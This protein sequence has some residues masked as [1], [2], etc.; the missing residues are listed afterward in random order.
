MLFFIAF[1]IHCSIWKW[2][3][4]WSQDYGMESTYCKREKRRWTG[5]PLV[6]QICWKYCQMSGTLLNLFILDIWYRFLPN[7]FSRYPVPCQIFCQFSGILPNISGIPGVY[8]VHLDQPPTP[9]IIF[10]I[11]YT[12]PLLYSAD[13]IPQTSGIL[14]RFSQISGILLNIL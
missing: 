1:C 4:L 2:K 12:I 6:G 11:I 14:P 5:Y 3:F 7:L 8:N 9:T 10:W 13:F